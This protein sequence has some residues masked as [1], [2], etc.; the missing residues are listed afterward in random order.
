MGGQ[1][2]S[3]ARSAWP[4]KTKVDVMHSVT[5]F[6]NNSIQ[7]ERNVCLRFEPTVVSHRFEEDE[8]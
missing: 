4:Y 1:S 5:G 6:L 7:L 3:Q 2:F 8:E